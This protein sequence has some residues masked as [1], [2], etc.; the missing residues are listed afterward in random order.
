MAAHAIQFY[1]SGMKCGGCAATVK[2]TLEGMDGVA[3]AEVDLEQGVAS[4][5]GDIDPQ[6]ACQ[7]LAE[8]GYPAVVKSN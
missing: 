5:A 4:V 1:V 6:S 3:E 7:L 8:A 2:Q